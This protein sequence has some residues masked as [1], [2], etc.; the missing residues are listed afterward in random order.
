MEARVS[1]CEQVF[2]AWSEELR[3]A[4][5]EVELKVREMRDKEESRRVEWKAIEK[6]AENT[7]EKVEMYLT[8]IEFR[9]LVSVT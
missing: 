5:E 6:Q 3:N 1:S 4:L 2:M 8:A 7:V 9:S